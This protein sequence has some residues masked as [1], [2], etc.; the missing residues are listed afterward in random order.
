M[1]DQ[2]GVRVTATNHSAVNN[3]VVSDGSASITAD[4]HS[5]VNGVSV[6]TDTRRWWQRLVARLDR[7][8]GTR[9][10]RKHKVGAGYRAT[11][12]D[13]PGYRPRYLDTIERLGTRWDV[14]PW[15][16]IAR[17]AT[18]GVLSGILILAIVFALTTRTATPTVSETRWTYRVQLFARIVRDGDSWRDQMP[19]R[20][21]DPVCRQEVRSHHDCE[22]YLCPGVRMYS[23]GR[24]GRSVCFAPTIRT[25]YHSCPDYSDYCRFHYPDWPMFR[26]E[27][28]GGVDHTPIRP[29]I[30]A[31]ACVPDPEVLYEE[32]THADR[33]VVDTLTYAVQFDALERGHW[34]IVPLTEREFDRY[35]TGE[36]WR[37]EFNHAGMFRPIAK[38]R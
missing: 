6:G 9:R 35:V 25:C 18:I 24:R 30:T 13:V 20:A 21:F 8:H 36:R 32:A 15:R 12:I 29:P 33:C 14:L 17:G 27:V 38:V 23:C 22:P 1:S 28:L 3:V 7:W 10:A 34:S 26:E 5:S 19:A 16:W 37:V 2:D 4:D 11:S 31:L